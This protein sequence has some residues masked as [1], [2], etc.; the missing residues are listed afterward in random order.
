MLSNLTDSQ[1]KYLLWGVLVFVVLMILIFSG[2]I[3]KSLHKTEGSLA[4]DAYGDLIETKTYG[5]PNSEN[6]EKEFALRLNNFVTDSISPDQ[7]TL[8][9][10]SLKFYIWDN[11][12]DAET[13]AVLDD[14]KITPKDTTA[15]YE[16][17]VRTNNNT[18]SFI[19]RLTLDQRLTI[20]KAEAV[21]GDAVTELSIKSQG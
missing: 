19:L 5:Q 13:K 20:I 6:N 14:G 1:K 18:S 4:K 8:L 15:I 21:N 11:I 9:K 2:V 7:V 17:K 12:N 16:S 10:K 3:S